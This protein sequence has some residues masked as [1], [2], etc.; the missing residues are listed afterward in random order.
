MGA[1]IH[2]YI[3]THVYIYANRVEQMFIGTLG[4]GIEHNQPLYNFLFILKSNYLHHGITAF[5]ANGFP[6]HGQIH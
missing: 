4:T 6:A 2:M 3:Q 1:H 5:F